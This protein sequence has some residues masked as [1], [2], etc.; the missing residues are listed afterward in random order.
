ID[1]STQLIGQLEKD[2]HGSLTDEV[3]KLK[4]ANGKFMTLQNDIVA[5]LEAGKERKAVEL[6]RASSNVSAIVLENAEVIKTNQV[7]AMKDA[8]AELTQYMNGIIYF[9]TGLIIIAIVAG[10]IISTAI[11][12]RISQPVQIVTDGLNAIAN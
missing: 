3:E 1:R 8:R 9:I 5:N 7:A 12:R 10:I 4:E 6:G 2:F 11:A